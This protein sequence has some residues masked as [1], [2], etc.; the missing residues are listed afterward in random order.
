MTGQVFAADNLTNAASKIESGILS[1]LNGI[2]STISHAAKE[3]GKTGLHRETEITKLLHKNYIAGKPYAINS[4]FIDNKGM[5]KFIEPEQYRSYEGS[6]ISGQ[7]AIIKM[8][9]TAV[10]LMRRS[11]VWIMF[12]AVFSDG[13][14]LRSSKRLFVFSA[15]LTC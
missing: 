3:T 15:V 5:M 4:T 7:E 1:I 9:K 12:Y 13:H 11:C 2:G 6:D 14:A 10:L 8:L